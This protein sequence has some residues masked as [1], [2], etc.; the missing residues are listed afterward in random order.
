MFFCKCYFAFLQVKWKSLSPGRGPVIFPHV[1]AHLLG[2]V[3][4]TTVHCNWWFFWAHPVSECSQRAL[5]GMGATQS[6]ALRLLAM[7]IHVSTAPYTC[8][9]ASQTCTRQSECWGK[10]VAQAGVI[11][12]G[13]QS[14]WARDKRAP[15]M[16]GQL[17]L[18]EVHL[19]FHC[20]LLDLL[21]SCLQHSIRCFCIWKWDRTTGLRG[22]E[23]YTMV[24]A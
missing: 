4:N 14:H 8:T 2:R 22:R 17:I 20:D 9:A 21:W 10:G 16:P 3:W 7:Q 13:W 24:E 15:E 23:S 6:L 12:C 19:L 18:E 5:P 1:L 11:S